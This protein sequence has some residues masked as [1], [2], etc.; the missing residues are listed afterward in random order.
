MN[1]QASSQLAPEDN[2]TSPMEKPQTATVWTYLNSRGFKPAPCH[3]DITFTLTPHCIALRTTFQWADKCSLPEEHK[4]HLR[5]LQKRRFFN[6]NSH[7]FDMEAEC[8][9]AP[10]LWSAW[11]MAVYISLELCWLW[12]NTQF[13][14]EVFHC[15]R[16][17]FLGKR[18]SCLTV[19]EELQPQHK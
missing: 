16:I 19:A 5:I 7:L 11:W 10:V 15:E 9:R 3:V 17:S 1:L 12:F 6:T 18:Q 14:Q 8:W 4:A 13:F 2:V